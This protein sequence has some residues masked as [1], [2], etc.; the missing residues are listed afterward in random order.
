MINIL[1]NGCCGHM[2]KVVADMCK[3]Q[4]DVVIVGGID[5]SAPEGDYG[6]PI[7]SSP[8]E[9]DIDFDVIIDFS[10]ATC[11]PALCEFAKNKKKGLVCCTTGIPEDVVSCLFDCSSSVP[12][13]KS[14]NMSYGMNVLFEIVRMATMALKDGSEIDIIEA[15]HRRKLDAP[16][17]TALM[18]ADVINEECDNK[19]DYVYDRS[20]RRSPRAQNEIGFSSIRGGNIVGEHEIMFIMDE[21]VVKISHSASTRDVFARGAIM[22]AK[23]IANKAPGMY[24][25]Q[26]ITA[27]IFD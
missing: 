14:A 17:G 26:D 20:Q 11:V 24:S 22:A 5:L 12:V 1:L 10:N 25:M 9:V 21:E 4:K 16:S 23:F 6:Y 2:G 3:Y 18:I 8:A 7:F 13:F 19:M 15:H 27:N